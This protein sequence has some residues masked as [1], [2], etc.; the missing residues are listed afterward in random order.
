M[1]LGNIIENQQEQLR[2]LNGTRRSTTAEDLDILPSPSDSAADL[3]LLCK[4]SSTEEN[5]RKQLTSYLRMYGSNKVGKTV[6]RT[7]R[8]IGTNRLWSQFSIKGRK[9]LP[10]KDRPLLRVMTKACS[11]CHKEAKI[12]ECETEIGECLKHATIKEGCN[13]YRSKEGQTKAP[14]IMERDRSLSTSPRDRSSRDRS[15]RNRSPRD[16]IFLYIVEIS[17]L[18]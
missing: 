14:E 1:K 17:C 3:K 18:Y 4:Q 13:K 8:C 10:V 9:K 16:R 7:I 6:R 2:L 5:F 11:K 15:P 12:T